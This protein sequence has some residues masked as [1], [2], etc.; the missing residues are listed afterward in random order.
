MAMIKE[1]EEAE[2]ERA[3]SWSLVGTRVGGPAPEEEQK[4]S[5]VGRRDLFR[6][7]EQVTNQMHD[8]RIKK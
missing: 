5:V 6:M 7:P 3:K 2:E 1:Q 4:E 8:V